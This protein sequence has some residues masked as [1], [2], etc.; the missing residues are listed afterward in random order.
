MGEG[1]EGRGIKWEKSEARIGRKGWEERGRVWERGKGG[2]EERRGERGEGGEEREGRGGPCE[3]GRGS[4]S[5][6]T[7]CD[8]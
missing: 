8:N 3:P 7:S 5:I 6:S 2:S 1:E 4:S